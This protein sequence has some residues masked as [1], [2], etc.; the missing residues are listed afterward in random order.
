MARRKAPVRPPFTEEAIYRFDNLL[1]FAAPNELREYLLEIYHHYI[2]HEHE[3]LPC[4]FS[5]M[6]ES[7][8]ILFDLLKFLEEEKK[9][10]LIKR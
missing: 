6:A 1:E 5:D 2:I 7:M 9:T 10:K 8:Q 4:N 3:R